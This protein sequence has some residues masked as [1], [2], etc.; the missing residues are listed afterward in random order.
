ME[1]TVFPQHLHKLHGD[2]T[3]NNA[4]SLLKL[5]YIETQRLPNM[6][7]KKSS[8]TLLHSTTE[9]GSGHRCARGEAKST[10]PP[11]DNKGLF[12]SFQI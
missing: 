5:R 2:G 12:F 10:P 9:Y 1:V 3:F 8:D 6:P 7:Q 4:L 11:T